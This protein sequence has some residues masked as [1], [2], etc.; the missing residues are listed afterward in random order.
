MTLSC[1]WITDKAGPLV[2]RTVQLLLVYL[3]IR[4]RMPRRAVRPYEMAGDHGRRPSREPSAGAM[5]L[6]GGRA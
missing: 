4:H 1:K 3:R 5:Q 2:C 6:I